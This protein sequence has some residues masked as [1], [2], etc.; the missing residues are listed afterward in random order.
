M[1]ERAGGSETSSS[2]Q[3]TEDAVVVAGYP[4]WADK[5]QMIDGVRL[6]VMSAQPCYSSGEPVRIVHVADHTEPGREV[7]VMGPKPVYGEYVDG[8]LMT[9]TPPVDEDPLAPLL[10]DGPVLPSPRADTNYEVTS[11]ILPPGEHEIRWK[12]ANRE[13]NVLRLRVED[14]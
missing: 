14:R 11:Y 7:Y 4:T 13:S 1:S 8:R 6:T 5:G 3:H 10:Y 9:A 12:M 2:G